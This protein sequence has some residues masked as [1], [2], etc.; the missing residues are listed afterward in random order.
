MNK[1]T[2]ELAIT[3]SVLSWSNLYWRCLVPGDNGLPPSVSPVSSLPM[4]PVSKATT[5]S[6]WPA[7]VLKLI[8]SLT[9]P[10]L[11][12]VLLSATGNCLC[13]IA[14]KTEFLC[15][16]PNCCRAAVTSQRFL[17]SCILC[18]RGLAKDLSTAMQTTTH[19]L[20]SNRSVFITALQVSYVYRKPVDSEKQTRF[21]TSAVV[22]KTRGSSFTRGL[23]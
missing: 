14:Q 8:P 21:Y 9:S 1:H 23:S 18:G 13:L 22:V 15:F 3:Y 11:L 5:H 7:S 20:V 2:A 10:T 6:D 4:A 19:Y 17:H 12:S 16:M